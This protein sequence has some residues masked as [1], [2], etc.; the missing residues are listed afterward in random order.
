MDAPWLPHCV[1]LDHPGQCASAVCSAGPQHVFV[2]TT[3]LCRDDSLPLHTRT[4]PSCTHASCVHA[5]Q[6]L[7]QPWPAPCHMGTVSAPYYAYSCKLQELLQPWPVTCHMGTVSA[8]HYAY[9]S[10]APQLDMMEGGMEVH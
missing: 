1:H 5:Q 6:E 8:P 10:D 4:W 2:L 9:S 3:H 7:L